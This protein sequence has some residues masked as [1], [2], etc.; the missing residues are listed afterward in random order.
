MMDNYEKE[1]TAITD[2]QTYTYSQRGFVKIT[3]M[4]SFP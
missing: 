3:Q 1:V 4:D 2:M